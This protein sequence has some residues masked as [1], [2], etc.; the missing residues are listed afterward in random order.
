MK[1]RLLSVG[2]LLMRARLFGSRRAR[3]HSFSALLVLS[4]ACSTPHSPPPSTRRAEVKDTLHGVELTDPYRWLEEQESPETWQ[5]IDA[6][7]AYA[8]SIVGESE[9]RARLRSQLGEILRQPEVGFP[10]KGGTYEYFTLRRASDELP[11]IYRRPAPPEGPESDAGDVPPIDPNAP[12]EV[13]LDPHPMSS[14]HTTRVD[15]LSLSAAGKYL[16]YSLRDGGEDEIE[17][18]LRDLDAKADLPDRLPRALYASVFFA[19]SGEGFYYT[20][21]S[22]QVGPRVRFHRVGAPVE[23]DEEIFGDGIGPTSF[24]ETLE[25]SDGKALVFAVNHGWARSDLY[26]KELTGEATPIVVGADARFYPQLHDDLLYIRTNL[27]AP[28]NRIVRI[29][30]KSPARDR[31]KEL[32]PENEDVLTAF[33][34]LDGKIYASYLH[35][36]TTRIAVHELDGPRAGEIPVPEHT[37]A[38]LRG[39]GPG[40]AFLTLTSV[41]LPPST[42][43]VELKTGERKSWDERAWDVDSETVVVQQVRYPSTDGTEIPMYLFYRRGTETDGENPT[44]LFGYGGFNAAQTPRFDP[45][46]AAWVEEGGLYAM[47]N[48]RGGSEYGETWHRAGMLGNKQNVFDDFLS[49][50]E[51][52]VEN[53]YTRPERLA[54]RGVSNGGLLVASAF[55]QRP[56]LFRAVVCGFPDL[57]MVRF[58]SFTETNNL[59]ALLEYGDASKPDEFEF[60]R[61][62]SPYQAVADGTAY[63]AVMLTSGDKDTRVS[64]LQ[65]RKMTARL[66]SATTSGRPVILRYHPKAGHAANYGMPV[67]RTLEDMAMEL[68]FLLGE[69]SPDAP[70]S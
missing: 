68:A 26:Y 39:A 64:P 31:W 14:D 9:R 70:E 3:V 50:A 17:V 21:R 2:S 62:Y 23:E 15:I 43:V 65:A 60:L 36:G 13:V 1:T 10:K 57:D 48:L 67:S 53:G 45:M 12:Y 44:L 33:T 47:A 37:T 51:F 41:T 66:Q 29:D 38:E 4:V 40:R 16:L 18:R 69:I 54:I 11:A 52:L 20:H 19:K 6:Q 49:A 42:D 5:W 27:D 35:H 32:V 30:P 24:L 56:E 58:Y 28:D 59:P 55:T 63:P 46:A 8:E 25:L 61:K 7:N 22:R 34:I